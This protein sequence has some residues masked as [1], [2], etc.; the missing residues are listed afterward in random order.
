MDLATILLL[1]ETPPPK[2]G[3]HNFL[4]EHLTSG[5]AAT[6][7]SSSS[8]GGGSP[9]HK[10]LSPASPSPGA[11]VSSARSTPIA[12]RKLGHHQ[13][14]LVR[15]KNYYCSNPMLNNSTNL[16]CNLDMESLEEMLKKRN[17]CGECSSAKLMM[18]RSSLELVRML[19]THSK[20]K[21]F[22]V[23]VSNVL[24]S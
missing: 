8:P 14:L 9:A 5:G 4:I 13:H 6:A 17:S 10:R 16:Y 19:F 22:S 15:S 3:Y 12:G 18:A 21:R 7:A 1:L 2:G 11:L 23:V 24:P 20:V